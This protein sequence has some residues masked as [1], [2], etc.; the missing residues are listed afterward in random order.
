MKLKMHPGLW[1]L[2]PKSS[3]WA[4]SLPEAA[5]LPSAWAPK[6]LSPLVCTQKPTMDGGQEPSQDVGHRDFQHKLKLC[7]KQSNPTNREN[8]GE[9]GPSSSQ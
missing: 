6:V 5:M 1:S 3:S 9:S 7:Q 2:D 8:G 4:R